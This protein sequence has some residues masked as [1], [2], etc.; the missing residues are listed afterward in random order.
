MSRWRPSAPRL[1]C[2]PRVYR[3]VV[4]ERV[5]AQLDALPAEAL[6]AYLELRSTLET[7]PSSGRPLHPAKPHG[8]LTFV[9]GPHGEGL[10]FYLVLDFDERVEVLDV[11][12]LG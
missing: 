9:F 6:S 12:W 3:I 10:V 4:D 8:V 5:Q 2:S 1:A 7:V 11:R